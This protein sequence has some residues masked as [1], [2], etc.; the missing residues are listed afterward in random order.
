MG[1][2]ARL[3]LDLDE[4][5]EPDRCTAEFLVALSAYL[6]GQAEEARQGFERVRDLAHAC[7]AHPARVLALSELSLLA[8]DEGD[9]ERARE[10][11][12]LAAGVVRQRGLEELSLLAPALCCAALVSAHF[13]EPDSSAAV[14]QQAQ[15]LFAVSVEPPTWAGVQCWETLARAALTRGDASAARTLL[16]EAQTLL[17]ES[18][19]EQ[20]RARVD[21]TWRRVAGRPLDVT[22]ATTLTRAE[23]RVLQL[24]PTHL[25]FAQIGQQLFVS[26]NTVKTQAVSAYRKLGVGSRSEAVER[27]QALNL[28]APAAALR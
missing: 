12:E 4:L 27:A 19:D 28:I 22:P 6:G 2:D 20:L 24:L 7:G 15:T 25:S 11:S 10:L 18:E 26:R 9:W 3:A 1:A 23:L 14:L 5:D 21:L 17:V 16:S 8:S 13:D